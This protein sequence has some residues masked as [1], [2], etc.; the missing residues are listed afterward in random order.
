MKR[1]LVFLLTILLYTLSFSQLINLKGIRFNGNPPQ[2]VIDVEGTIKPRFSIDYDEASRLLFIELPGTE[3]GNN[4]KS[5]VLNGNYIEKINVVKY[6]NSTGVFAFLNK[7][8]NF[9]TSY[10]TDPVR[11][12]MDFSGKVNEK[13]YTIVID[14][15]HGG[16]DP[17]AVGFNKYHEK[18]IVFSV[19]NYLRN[20]LIRDFNVV[21]TRS[22]DNFVSLANRPRT[23][24]KSK[25]DMFISIHANA[26]K[27]GKGSG[28]EAFYFSKKSSPYAERV[29]S[30]E[31]SFGAKYGEDS[32]DIAQIM[33]ELAYKK[34]Q[35]ESIKL[36]E[37]LASTYSKKLNMKNRGVHGA[38]FAV[39][40]GFD[41]PGVLLELGFIS[42]KYD[43]WKLKQSKYQRLMAEEIADN[44]R[45][46]FY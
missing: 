4:F 31:N 11:V 10:R 46:Y 6:S 32:G 8:V 30:F 35:E 25:G 16:K 24:N 21:M 12:V 36:G 2:M 29:A 22:T 34:N 17:G 3:A 26:D 45:K 14:A 41:G 19:A 40:R 13:E 37:N 44:I 43:V 27:S 39:L 9:R 5:R 18:D 1:H 38:N 33:G 42:N 23:G 20:E 28:F 7:N 15:G